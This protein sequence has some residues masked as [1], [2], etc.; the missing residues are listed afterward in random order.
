[1]TI[2][3]RLPNDRA[4]GA[5]QPPSEVTTT[6]FRPDGVGI[7]PDRP[8]IIGLVGAVL[9][10][11]HDEWVDGRRCLG[12]KILAT[13]QLVPITTKT[14]RTQSAPYQNDESRTVAHHVVGAC[15]LLESL[16]TQ[17]PSGSAVLYEWRSHHERERVGAGM[18]APAGSIIAMD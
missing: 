3:C 12:L 11:Q 5:R 13:S 18:L 15:P 7:F 17:Q 4:T 10:E 1:M 9:A 8:S 14:T 2:G 6:C 16:C